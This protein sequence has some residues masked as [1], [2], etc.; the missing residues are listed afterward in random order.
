VLSIE[1]DIEFNHR[2]GMATS[3]RKKAIEMWHTSIPEGNRIELAKVLFC[4][5]NPPGT[6]YVSGSQDQLGILLPGFNRLYYDNGFWPVDIKSSTDNDTLAFMEKHIYLVALPLRR[7]GYDPYRNANI[8]REGV[9]RLAEA[10]DKIWD[11]VHARDAKAWG[12]ATTESFNAQLA[13]F[14]NM[15]SPEMEENIAKYKDVA[16]GWKIS[17]AGGGGYLVLISENPI[18]NGIRIRACRS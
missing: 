15:I 17:G 5:N 4:V 14:P 7:S 2:S 10:T 11:A 6:E 1:P 18:E 9:R 13:M 8:T 12:L 3:S 16:Y